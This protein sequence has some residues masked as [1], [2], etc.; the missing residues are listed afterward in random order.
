VAVAY[1]GTWAIGRA[2]VVWVTEGRAASA[3]TVRMLSREGLQRGRD[4]ARDLSARGRA[5]VAKAS[6]R[7]DRLRAHVPGLRRRVRTQAQAAG[8]TP[9]LPPPLPP[10]R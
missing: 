3:E 5:G 4:V 6:G 8:A 7:W 2:V 10:P 1:G 9:S